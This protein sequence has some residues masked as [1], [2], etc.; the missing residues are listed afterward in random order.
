[1]TICLILKVIRDNS[2]FLETSN[3]FLFK[4]F[5]LIKILL[6]NLIFLFTNANKLIVSTIIELN[7]ELNFDIFNNKFSFEII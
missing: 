4:V 1:M 2:L 7:F 3:I 6:T 5:F